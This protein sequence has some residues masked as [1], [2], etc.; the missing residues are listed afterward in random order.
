[1]RSASSESSSSRKNLPLKK[2][3]KRRTIKPKKKVLAQYKPLKKKL[4][5]REKIAQKIGSNKLPLDN[6]DIQ[7]FY[8]ELC[9]RTK[10]KPTLE[11]T[12]HNSNFSDLFSNENFCVEEGKN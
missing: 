3:R 7:L 2:I 6:K 11:K 10:T 9:S 12:A 4:T 5:L 1:M 8:P